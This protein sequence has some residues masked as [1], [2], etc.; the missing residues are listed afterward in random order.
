M[1]IDLDDIQ[2]AAVVCIISVALLILWSV[3]PQEVPPTN[4][5]IGNS[6]ANVAEGSKVVWVDCGFKFQHNRRIIYD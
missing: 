1:F 3:L 2:F 5:C 6:T 4:V